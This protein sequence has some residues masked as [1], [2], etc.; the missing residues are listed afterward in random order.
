MTEAS[1]SI[2]LLPCEALSRLWLSA[3]SSTASPL[4]LRACAPKMEISPATIAPISGRNTIAWI[5]D[6]LAFHQIDV[7][8]RDRAAIAEVNHQYRKADRRLR[9]RHR[10]H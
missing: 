2:R 5:I 8:D 1:S 10:Q 9:R 3:V 6:A 4:G 7:F